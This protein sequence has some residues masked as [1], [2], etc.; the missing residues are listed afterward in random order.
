MAGKVFI[1]TKTDVG[2]GNA[3]YVIGAFFKHHLAVDACV[4]P[5]TFTIMK[6][7]PNRA[8]KRGA[9]LDCETID[10]VTAASIAV[11]SE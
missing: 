11:R 3:G 2:L 8:Y 6:V 7:D 9:M 1:V 10:N 5:G 4:G